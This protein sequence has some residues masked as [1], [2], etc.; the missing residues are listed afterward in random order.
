MKLARL[1]TNQRT[2]IANHL[3]SLITV[4]LLIC[5]AW[6]KKSRADRSAGI[7][8]DRC[9]ID[10]NDTADNVRSETG[11]GGLWNALQIKAEDK[12]K[13]NKSVRQYLRKKGHM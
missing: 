1:V 5:I 12:G 6:L 8:N 4:T 11:A 3:A 7:N 2:R 10:T 9:D 13:G